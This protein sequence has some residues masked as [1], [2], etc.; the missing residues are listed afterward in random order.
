MELRVDQ[1]AVARGGV[2]VLE[3]V[4][5]VLAPGRGLVLRG[6]NGIGKTTLLRTIAGLQP[7]VA[8]TISVTADVIA[9]AAH[10]DGLKAVLS[11]EENLRFW[12]AIHGTGAVAVEA[13][14]EA[15]DLRALPG[16][17]TRTTS[18]ALNDSAN[19]LTD[20]GVS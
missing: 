13:A 5:F 12:A 14:L 8:G 15:M 2:T 11:V 19:D 18:P 9:Y 17:P 6:P 1:L 20:P 4:S 10:A 7:A 16:I 3:A